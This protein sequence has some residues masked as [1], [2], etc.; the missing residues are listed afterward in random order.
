L[1]KIANALTADT[2]E[3]VQHIFAN[4]FD[5]QSLDDAFEAYVQI[6]DTVLDSVIIGNIMNI[7]DAC[8]WS[9]LVYTKD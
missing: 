6:K 7:A 1:K 4:E 2:I 5:L 8:F 3:E 9:C